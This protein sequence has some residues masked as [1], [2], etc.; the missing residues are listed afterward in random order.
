MGLPS[1]A[2]AYGPSDEVDVEM[3]LQRDMVVKLLAFVK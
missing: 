2:I 1:I 3:I